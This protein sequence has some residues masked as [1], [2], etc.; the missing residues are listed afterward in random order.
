MHC[1]TDYTTAP[2]VEYQ[3]AVDDGSHLMQCV[4]FWCLARI[5]MNRKERVVAQL[6]KQHVLGLHGNRKGTIVAKFE[7]SHLVVSQTGGYERLRHGQTI[8]FGTCNVA[9]LLHA[10]AVID[11]FCLNVVCIRW[12]ITHA[13]KLWRRHR[14]G[15]MM[16]YSACMCQRTEFFCA[17]KIAHVLLHMYWT[18]SKN[19]VACCLMW[20]GTKWSMQHLLQLWIGLRITRRWC[21]TL[22]HAEISQ[23][24]WVTVC[25]WSCFTCWSP[26][27]VLQQESERVQQTWMGLSCKDCRERNSEN[28]PRGIGNCNTIHPWHFGSKPCCSFANLKNVNDYKNMNS[29]LGAVEDCWESS[30]SY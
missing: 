17:P 3:I 10:N 18:L 12:K 1:L 22:V 25:W 8:I 21:T 16:R 29:A 27:S 9:C 7:K 4:K 19:D 14:R 2:L 6:T 15:S 24:L 30:M 11:M 20:S 5:V 26:K 23:Q 13:Q 28:W